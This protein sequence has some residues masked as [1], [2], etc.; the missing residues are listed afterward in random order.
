MFQLGDVQLV[1][2]VIGWLNG[3]LSPGSWV[4][5]MLLGN[6]AIFLPMG[7]LLPLAANVK[8]GRKMLCLSAVIPLLCEALQLVF[9][10]SFDIDDLL[11]N[12]LGMMI[13]AALSFG[14]LKIKSPTPTHG[15]AA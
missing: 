8:S 3:T 11:C 7:L 13:G 14:I 4:K 1:P 6:V 5:T 12:F 9:G 2:S 15:G 10:R